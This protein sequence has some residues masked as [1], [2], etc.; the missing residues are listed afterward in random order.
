[1][2][3]E[4]NLFGTQYNTVLG[5]PTCDRSG[6]FLIINGQD[7]NT[8]Q[9]RCIAVINPGSNGSKYSSYRPGAYSATQDLRP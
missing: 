3:E 7:V 2:P 5:K 6:R 1:M 8:S 9:R 4:L